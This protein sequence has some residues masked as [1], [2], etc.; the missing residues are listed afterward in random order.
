MLLYTSSSETSGRRKKLTASQKKTTNGFRAKILKQ[1][2]TGI[3]DIVCLFSK[4]S[5]GCVC[6]QI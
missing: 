6:E 4:Q 3:F 5:T 2:N 1:L